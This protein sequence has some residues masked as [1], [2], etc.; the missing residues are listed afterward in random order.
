LNIVNDFRASG[1]N[2]KEEN[3]NTDFE[4]QPFPVKFGRMR[5][6]VNRRSPDASRN[7]DGFRR[8]RSAWTAATSAPL[9]RATHSWVKTNGKY[10]MFNP[11][12]KIPIWNLEASASS[13]VIWK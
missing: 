2:R 11:L 13:A 5:A 7:L 9:L 12:F 10:L 8:S 1:W 3:G 6:A 4:H